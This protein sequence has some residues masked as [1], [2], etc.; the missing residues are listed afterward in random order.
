MKMISREVNVVVGASSSIGI[1]LLTRFRAKNTF[2]I[3]TFN[4]FHDHTSS[5]EEIF[6]HLDLGS[7]ESIQDFVFKVGCLVSHI[8]TIVFLS[9]VL[10][11]KNLSEYLLID[12]EDVITVNFS[13]QVKLIKSLLPF[14]D[15]RSHIIMISS[16]S[17]QRG[18]YDPIYAASKGAILSFVKAVASGSSEFRINAIAPG[19]IKNSSMFFQMSEERREYHRQQVFNGKLLDI[20]DLARIIFDLSRE[21]WKHLNGACIDLNG[22]QYLR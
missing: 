10:P 6:L 13:G 17:A 11:G 15:N 5:D 21:H 18:S 20:S 9:G 12:L 1:E 19:L 7:D 16:I 3:G 2:T 4:T 22:G 8:D 14:L